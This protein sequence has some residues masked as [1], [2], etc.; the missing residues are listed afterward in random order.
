MPIRALRLR[1]RALRLDP[2]TWPADTRSVPRASNRHPASRDQLR[3]AED[4][5]NNP[6]TLCVFARSA[7]VG[8][9]RGV[10]AASPFEGS[11]EHWQ[12]VKGPIAVNR[13]C[14]ID[15]IRQPPAWIEGYGTER[16]PDD[17]SDHHRDDTHQFVIPANP[18]TEQADPE[19]RERVNCFR[20]EVKPH[21]IGTQGPTN[22]SQFPRSL[23]PKLLGG[24]ERHRAGFEQIL[25][26]DEAIGK[27]LGD[28]DRMA[29]LVGC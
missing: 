2:E 28:L 13:H 20:N 6:A 25:L 26:A 23:E 10:I 9:N 12:S 19:R 27:S 18:M 17:I 4:R 15:H 14:Q 1:V 5:I 24:V 3:L 16:I 22:P 29:A 8:K 21:L 11:G 7:A